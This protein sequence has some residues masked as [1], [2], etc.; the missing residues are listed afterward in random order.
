MTLRR[1][2]WGLIQIPLNAARYLR[3]RSRPFFHRRRLPEME[4][5]AV[6][7]YTDKL[8]YCPGQVIRFYLHSD[9]G[10]GRLEIRHLEGPASRSRAPG[11]VAV[12]NW[13]DSK[14][15]GVPWTRR[16]REGC[17]WTVT[18]EVP[19]DGRF[20]RGY[21]ECRL[22]ADGRDP[23][24]SI[25]FIVQ[26]STPRRV[27]LLAPCTTWVAYNNYGGQSFYEN[28]VD[29]T[30]PHFLSARRPNHQRRIPSAFDFFDL[31]V[32]AHAFNWFAERWPED[33][34]L[35][36]DYALEGPLE[37][38]SIVVLLYH[39]EYVTGAM[40]RG[41]RRL[42]RRASLL[43][44]GANQV[45]WQVRWH[46]QY[47]LLECRKDYTFFK[48]TLVR[49][50]LWRHSFFPEEALFGVCYSPPGEGS[51]A[52]FQ[53]VR[54]NHWL[55]SG[56]ACL[57]GV[58]GITGYPV[59]G[60]ET[61]KPVYGF[62]RKLDILASGLNGSSTVHGAVYP[63]TAYAWDASGGGCITFFSPGPGMGVLSLGSIHTAA[64]LG[65]DAVLDSIVS[66]FVDRYR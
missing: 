9:T 61:D 65:V 23:A 50:K 63:D 52:P 18:L 43:N 49:G 42:A 1:C 34:S 47:T 21:Y 33:I 22:G 6:E 58:H 60:D 54:A 29:G 38:V 7:G 16:S 20:S 19:V 14:Q 8:S 30:P 4:A 45:Y 55:M 62:A 27:L 35:M 31:E 15:S 46:Q 39:C 10:Y 25:N 12:I 59:C 26:D 56:A 3:H 40:Y 51:Y 37:G 24:S 44:L 32:E 66:R 53:V 57:F 36:P 17:G 41:L 13:S 11:P 64:G 5:R 2:V 28:G 48:G